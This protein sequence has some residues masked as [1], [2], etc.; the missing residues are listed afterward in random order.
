MEVAEKLKKHISDAMETTIPEQEQEQGEKEKDMDVDHWNAAMKA[1]NDNA[2]D[3]T[4]E[5][6]WLAELLQ[7]KLQLLLGEECKY[8]HILEVEPPKAEGNS[9]YMN[10]LRHYALNFTERLALLLAL[11]AHIHPA[12]LGTFFKKLET[13]AQVPAAIH[14][15]YL[16]TGETLAFILAGDSLKGRFSLNFLFSPDHLF[17]KHDILGL[18]A[19]EADVPRLNGLLRISLGYVDYFTTGK[20]AL[21]NFG[22]D[23]P[24]R[25]ITTGMDW[26]D[27]VLPNHT[28]RQLE[29]IRLWMAH[30][31]TLLNNWGLRKKLRPRPPG[32]F[33]WPTGNR[34][35]HYRLPAGPILRKA[36][37]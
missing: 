3:L 25:H 15:D 17:A 29:E 10:F 11:T 21:P 5:L 36:C 33:L 34:K 13:V 23:F 4:S 7:V 28:L 31:D 8:G 12:L 22:P 16:P 27:L 37:I 19:V 32:A 24:A 20:P 14:S 9:I 6:E 35:I 1:L 18:A 26:K 2:N 30:G